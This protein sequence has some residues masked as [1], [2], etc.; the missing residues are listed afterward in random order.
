MSD[1]KQLS[2]VGTAIGEGRVFFIGIKLI[3]LAVFILLALHKLRL[4]P[5]VLACPFS[6]PVGFS[7][8]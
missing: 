2:V 3:W 1:V 6:S 5:A 7:C 8:L 4:L